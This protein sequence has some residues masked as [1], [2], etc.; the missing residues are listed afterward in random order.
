MKP[1]I[2]ISNKCIKKLTKMKAVKA[3]EETFTV[4]CG[5]VRDPSKE[6]LTC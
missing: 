4:L 6:E 2:C 1:V 5:G 3:E